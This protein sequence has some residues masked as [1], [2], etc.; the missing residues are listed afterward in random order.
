MCPLIGLGRWSRYYYYILISTLVKFFKEDILGV[1][2][3]HQLLVHLSIIH[4]PVILLLIGF[5]S[6]FIICFIAWFIMA[7]KEYKNHLIK[8]KIFIGIIILKMKRVLMLIN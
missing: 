6:D 5:L 3:D 4:H 2:V 1:S 8:K 7:Y